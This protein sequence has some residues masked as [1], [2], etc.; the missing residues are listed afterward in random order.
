MSESLSEDYGSW[1]KCLFGGRRLSQFVAVFQPNNESTFS[2]NSGSARYKSW[3]TILSSSFLSS[4]S[5]WST[6]DRL[7]HHSATT[8]TSLANIQPDFRRLLSFPSPQVPT[9]FLSMPTNRS[10]KTRRALLAASCREA[11]MIRNLTMI[12]PPRPDMS[13]PN[14]QLTTPLRFLVNWL[15]FF[16]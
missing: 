14:S 12:S 5:I 7:H 15:H 13:F 3:S 9:Y 11:N 10:N 2:T 16:N 8:E 6:A 1:I 4:F